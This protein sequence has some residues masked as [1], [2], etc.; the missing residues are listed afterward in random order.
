MNKVKEFFD[1]RNKLLGLVI[2]LLV[3]VAIIVCVIVFVDVDEIF[4]SGT[5]NP[6]GERLVDDYSALNGKKT[7]DGKVYPKVKIP[8]ENNFK[9]TDISEV[10]GLLENRGDAVIYFG[11]P[12]CVYCRT[13]IQILHD[14]VKD[15]K[16][17]KVYYL[18]V[19]KKGK[20]YDKLVK[21][22]GEKFVDE[23]GKI[24]S[25]L[26]VFVANGYIV[27]YNK[28]TLFSQEDP[29]D[30]MDESQIKGLSQIYGYGIKDVL[31]SLEI[32]DRINSAIE[33]N[34]DA[35]KDA[36]SSSSDT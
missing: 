19:E 8:V 7:L 11:Y 21:A 26:V 6:D 22:M 31:E 35:N 34:T 18:D 28:G 4:I 27:S 2:V 32:K 14:T 23:E 33:N 24:I 29:F 3:I 17:D 5:K 13:A 1:D 25:P 36:V 9:Y 12:S 15:T 16:L 30:K 20:G 10:L